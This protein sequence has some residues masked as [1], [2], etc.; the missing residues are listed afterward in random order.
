MN[1]Y[2][3]RDAMYD[4]QLRKPFDVPLNVFQRMTIADRIFSKIL[5]GR[6]L[7][8]NPIFFPAGN[9]AVTI[10]NMLLS[11]NYSDLLYVDSFLEVN[12]H[13]GASIIIKPISAQ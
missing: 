3:V 7:F 13:L 2:D 4:F 9:S 1:A 11:G 6:K 8:M 10:L 12:D 5:S